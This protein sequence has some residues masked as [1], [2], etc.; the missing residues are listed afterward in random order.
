[1]TEYAV[2]VN[3]DT[4]IGCRACQ[5]ACKVWNGLKAEET[6]FNP[7]GYTNP[8]DLSPNTWM[9]M[10]FMEGLTNSGPFWLF[11]KTQCM[12]CSEAP[13]AKACPA[14]A[15]EVHPSGAVVIRDDKCIGCQ[16]CIEACPYNVPRY[17][18]KRNK[19]YKCTMCVD[20]IQNGLAPACVEA[21][22]TDALVFGPY[23]KL[24]SEYKSAGYDIYGDHVNDYVGHTHYLYATKKFKDLGKEQGKKWYEMLGLPEDPKGHLPLIKEGREIGAGLAVAALAGV[25]LHAVYWRAKR[26]EEKKASESG[27]PGS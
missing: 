20:R 15:I 6:E 10:E 21:C 12:H 3:L 13:C 2:M 17:D 23:D 27:E 16:Y 8:T 19:V 7:D 14:N 5:V 4:C 26:I 9:I 24:V 1:M 25:A 22:P 18:P 11:K